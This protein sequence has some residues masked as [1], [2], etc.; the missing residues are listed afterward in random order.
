MS[1]EPPRLLTLVIGFV[2]WSSGLVSLYGLNA[3]GCAFT[4]P[5]AVQRSAL[6]LLL[7]AHVGALAWMSVSCWRRWRTR[8]GDSSQ[9]TLFM[10]D[11]A[12][13]TTFAALAATILTLAP[14]FVLTLCR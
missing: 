6:L 1:T 8:D 7:A 9:T 5:H 4:W 3:I 14:S 13:G 12:L 11:V 10:N 2:I